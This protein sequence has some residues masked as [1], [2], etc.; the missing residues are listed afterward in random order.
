VI[1]F[2]CIGVMRYARGAR[3]CAI[4]DGGT[5]S[6][7]TTA[8]ATASLVLIM[9]KQILMTLLDYECGRVLV[10]VKT[11]RRSDLQI[12]LMFQGARIACSTSRASL[13]SSATMS[14]GSLSIVPKRL[15]LVV[16]V[17]TRMSKPTRY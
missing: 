7:T 3:S 17:A 6:A 2:E 14:E 16:A 10:T 4:S 9:M 5:R 15:L 11:V 12:R 13:D 8:V 1:A